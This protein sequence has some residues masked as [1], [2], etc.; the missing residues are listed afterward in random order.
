MYIV[1]VDD[2]MNRKSKVIVSIIG[3]SIV[4]LA[5]LGI[6]YAYYL[7]RIEGNTNTNSISI[8]T[9]DLQ[10]KYDDG[11]GELVA[12]NIMPGSEILTKT[13][14]ITNSGNEIIH[15]YS[16]YLEN[17][18]NDFVNIND[19]K[20]TIT[21][22]SSD[23]KDCN[24]NELSYPL[25][26][27]SIVTNTIE[28]NVTHTYT[29]D[30]EYL[31]TGVDQSDDMGKIIKGKI[32]VYASNENVTLYGN[33]YDLDNGGLYS[34][35]LIGVKLVDE[36]NVETIVNIKNGKYEIKNISP[37]AYY[38]HVYETDKN[39]SL[40][41]RKIEINKANFFDY[42]F[43]YINYTNFQTNISM[44]LD[45]NLSDYSESW[46]I[47]EDC[48]ED[49]QD[50]PHYIA[51]LEEGMSDCDWD[52]C[53]TYYDNYEVEFVDISNVISTPIEG[54]DF[55]K[56][57]KLNKRILNYALTD[58]GG[59]KYVKVPITPIGEPITDENEKLLLHM[60]DNLGTSYIFRGNVTNNY[61]NF[62]NMCFR[63]VRIDGAGNIKII[64][65]DKTSECQE[66]SFLTENHFVYYG[67]FYG[68][69]DYGS[70]LDDSNFDETKLTVTNYCLETYARE[71]MYDEEN[72]WYVFST[73]AYSRLQT[74]PS[75]KCGEYQKEENNYIASLTADEAILAGLIYNG[76]SFS[77]LIVSDAI[78]ITNTE[79]ELDNAGPEFS[80]F[81]V[82]GSR[83]ESSYVNRKSFNVRP[84]ITLSKNVIAKGFGTQSNPY[85][86]E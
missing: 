57:S 44:Q 29:M 4:L 72:N 48:L 36:N 18:E 24:G 45:I 26:D 40:N 39:N 11:S 74:A 81:V 82:N 58:V 59:T 27:S 67:E 49:V 30:I 50:D 60:E 47:D 12:S 85:I 63:I 14:S 13:F 83:I 20:V 79:D 75:L 51:C 41:N 86:V 19:L 2:I 52:W 38:L 73:N 77:H 21:C 3:I 65:T 9:A 78:Y 8:T 23:N 28:P 32:Q 62:N 25:I 42:G 55:D 84:V 10:L 6:T 34:E 69:I 68:Y 37:G 43:N 15:D 22:S 61:L 71:Y 66:S 80:W 53:S 35:N 46:D 76:E 56:E 31:E 5:L 70:W 1:K 17:V 7:T 64:L 54:I 33:I 16:V